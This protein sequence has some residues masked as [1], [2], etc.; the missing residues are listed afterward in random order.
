MNRPSE[1]PQVSRPPVTTGGSYVLVD[2]AAPERAF[3]RPAARARQ[4]EFDEIVCEVALYG[5]AEDTPRL[6]ELPTAGQ[7]VVAR[8]TDGH[9]YR[10][11]VQRVSSKL[12]RCLLEFIEYGN[13]MVVEDLDSLCPCPPQFSLD[14][15]PTLT[16]HVTLQ[17]TQ[18]SFSDA[19]TAYLDKLKDDATELKLSIPSGEKTGPSKTPVRLTV[20]ETNEDVNR[21]VDALST[22]E[23][24]KILQRGGDVLETETYHFHQVTYVDPP[25]TGGEMVILDCSLLEHAMVSGHVQNAEHAR[26]AAALLPRLEA[27]CNSAL[28]KDPYLPKPEELC[29]AMC[30]TKK[31]WLRGVML[32]Q[33]GGPGGAEAQ[34]LFYDRGDLA[35]LPVSQLRKMMPEFARDVPAAVCTLVIK[36]FPEQPTAEQLER[37]K[38]HLQVS[39][40]GVGSLR[41]TRVSKHDVGEY[42]VTAPDLIQAI[43]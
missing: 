30:P 16:S 22:P 31:Q 9:H 28:A 18:D 32:Q 1:P 15:R 20:V 38:K 42:L 8:F 41:V 14:A 40:A 25:A 33:E 43:Q 35:T 21:T 23:W 2:A 10:A 4:G 11:L 17:L 39:P 3:L 19:A 26:K 24:Q 27:Y 37:A 13:A 5:A 29:I 34:I 7:T 6:K 12:K 36:D